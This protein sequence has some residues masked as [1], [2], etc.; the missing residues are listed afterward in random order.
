[1]Q[2]CTLR[3]LTFYRPGHSSLRSK[4]LKVVELKDILAKASVSAPAKANKTDLIAR[5]L[6]SQSALNVYNKMHAPAPAQSQTDDLVSNSLLTGS[7]NL[8]AFPS[9]RLP[10]SM[11]TMF[12][13]FIH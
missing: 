6:A 12:Q 4:Q 9:L 5:I 8:K 1:M 7:Q 11:P 2:N 3:F 13:S 10:K